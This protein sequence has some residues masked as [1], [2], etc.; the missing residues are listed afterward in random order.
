MENEKVFYTYGMIKPDGMINIEDIVKMIQDQGLEL[1]FWKVD[2][3]DE[4]VIDE[5]YSHCIGK[6]FYSGMKEN[7]LSGP[8]LKML[9]YDKDGDA[10]KKY[11]KVLGA[12]NSALANFDTIRGKFGNKQVTYK[13]AAHGSGS[14][15]EAKAEVLRFFGDDIFNLFD[16]ICW[17]SIYEGVLAEHFGTDLEKKYVDEQVRYLIHSDYKIF[18][19]TKGE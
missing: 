8:V 13:N 19:K 18:K 10:V 7:L 2:I 15:S 17:L 6:D 16:G 14:P 11:R 3:L 5:N 1:K 4:K 12:T 9:I